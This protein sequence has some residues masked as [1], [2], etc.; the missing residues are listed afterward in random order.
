[1]KINSIKVARNY[2]N[3]VGLLEI[4]QVYGTSSKKDVASV[5][6]PVPLSD[7]ISIDFV[8]LA[9][10]H[11]LI[12]TR[13]CLNVL[14]L[15]SGFSSLV[16]AHALKMNS[17]CSNGLLPKS[18]RREN[19]WHLDSIDES[20]AWLEITMSR[21]PANL[22][23]YVTFHFRSVS[24][25]TFCD[26]PVTYY[27]DIPNHPYDLIYVDGPSQ[28]SHGESDWLGFSTHDP[29]RMP[30]SADVLRIEHFLQPG[31]LVLFDGRSANAGFFEMNA[32]KKW[33]KIRS[34]FHDQTIFIDES[35][36]LG[37][38]NKE[39]LRYWGKVNF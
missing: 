39:F 2:L 6:N 20:K 26:R 31:T 30:M 27:R 33:R 14:E 3:S 12:T 29:G 24:L 10:L 19:P 8:D 38:Y 13:K 32:Q 11:S 34:R 25:A 15:G 18:L 36:V 4:L 5:I 37:K 9:R 21:I 7:P 23:P 22:A 17:D 35:D 1:M 16:I 28:Y